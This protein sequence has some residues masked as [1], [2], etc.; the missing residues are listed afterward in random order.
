MQ[1]ALSQ[2]LPQVVLQT[3][4]PGVQGKWRFGTPFL[5]SFAGNCTASTTKVQ[6]AGFY[7]IIKKIKVWESI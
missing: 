4:A 7:V 3:L 2:L 1:C 5:V 6:E